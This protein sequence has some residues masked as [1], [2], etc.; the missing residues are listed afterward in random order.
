MTSARRPFAEL[1]SAVAGEIAQTV[2]YR[3]AYA[4]TKSDA[5]DTRSGGNGRWPAIGRQVE[6]STLVPAE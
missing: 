2:R 1:I 3:L 5:R 6:R 4:K